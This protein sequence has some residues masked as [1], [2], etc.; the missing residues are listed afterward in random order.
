ML[1]MDGHTIEMDVLVS[2]EI[3]DCAISGIS[4]DDGGHSV[5]FR[6]E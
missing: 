4:I 5:L 2:L 6:G 1:G 3:I